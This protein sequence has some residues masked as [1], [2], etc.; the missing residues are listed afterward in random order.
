MRELG[1]QMIDGWRYGEELGLD[2]SCALCL[3]RR[4]G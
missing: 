2:S 3:F 4:E 1:W